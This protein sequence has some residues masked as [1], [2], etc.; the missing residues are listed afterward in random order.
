MIKK[1]SHILLFTILNI[2][3]VNAHILQKSYRNKQAIERKAFYKILAVQY[4]NIR[5]YNLPLP[6]KLGK[7]NT[8]M[9]QKTLPDKRREELNNH[10][11]KWKEMWYLLSKETQKN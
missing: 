10:I 4:L 11:Q 8:K 2:V 3:R 1:I 6:G 7:G 9:L 5:L